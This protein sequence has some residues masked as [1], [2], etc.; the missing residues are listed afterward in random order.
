MPAVQPVA[1][2]VI[3]ETADHGGE[4]SHQHHSNS[5]NASTTGPALSRRIFSF[6][7]GAAR[8][9]SRSITNSV[10]MSGNG[11]RTRTGS[12]RSASRNISA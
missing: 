11:S 7:R 12:M 1:G 9:I 4:A 3:P 8:L 2:R 10:W 5:K 6:S